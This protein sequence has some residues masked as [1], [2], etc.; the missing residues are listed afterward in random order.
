MEYKKKDNKIYFCMGIAIILL[1]IL[2]AC[3]ISVVQKYNPDA[4]FLTLFSEGL[5]HFNNNFF[6]LEYSPYLFQNIGIM[7]AIGAFGGVLLKVEL[8]KNHRDAVGKEKGDAKWNLDL[9]NYNKTYTDPPKSIKNDGEKNMIL[10]QDVFL[11]MDG[12][13]TY[14]NNNILVIGGSGSG[15]SRFLIKPN[16]LQANCSFLVTDP[17]GELLE[18]CGVPLQKK[19]YKIKVFNLIEMNHSCCYNPFEYIRDDLGVMILI[20]CLIK[21]T[22]P[23][24]ASKGDPFWEKS[25]TAL[26]QA[27]MFYLKD[28]RPKED[29]NFSNIMKL[30]RLAEVDEKNP[31]A[32]SP[33]DKLFDE[34]PQ[35]SIA[36]KQYRIFKMG[37]GKTL[38]SILISCATR[39]T[40]F[41]LKE[42]ENL[43]N[44]DT[45]QLQTLGDEKQAVFVI[46]PTADDTYNF[47]VSMMYSQ[48]FETLYYEAENKYPHRKLI[49]NG[50]KYLCSFESDEDANKYIEDMKSASI[51]KV[52]N[53][54][55]ILSK[56][57]EVLKTL[58]NKD[59]A[60]EWLH[61]FSGNLTI[62]QG[63]KRLPVHLRCLLDEFA[64]IGEIPEFDKKLATMRKHEISCTIVLQSEAQ[65]KDRY[66]KKWE[67][68]MGNCDTLLFLGGQEPTTLKDISER[69]G[70]AN[71]VVRNN[72]RNRGGKGGGSSLSYN[73]DARNLMDPD[74]IMRMPNDECILIIRGLRPFRGKKY[75]YTSHPNYPMTGDANPENIFP[76]HDVFNNSVQ[77][78]D[79]STLKAK[80]EKTEAETKRSAFSKEHKPLSKKPVEVNEEFIKEQ[81]LDTQEGCKKVKPAVS[82]FDEYHSNYY[83]GFLSDD[84]DEVVY[85]TSE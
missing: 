9:K 8:E 47:L 71:I 46:I 68:I 33:L 18:A 63:G 83:N 11:S 44:R 84:E 60:K 19:G 30:L 79:L 52:G 53:V 77:E 48:M 16:L 81:K 10:T 62:K 67:G 21:N 59:L 61:N 76:L 25:E 73:R 66:E 32:K 54:Y 56:Q 3:H 58:Y 40:V 45:M 35:D 69:L 2:L 72:S 26:L 51:E 57:K 7:L 41:N 12:S 5:R 36:A 64:N 14:R 49:Y 13:Q 85:F 17:S 15:K 55:R 65:L 82:S 43:T 78:D 23:A 80:S 1:L 75:D 24:G 74:E 31:N 29:R 50:N 34:I 28:F 38:K 37:A 70:K 22:T 39:L 4:S 6:D 20:N 42:V 27:L